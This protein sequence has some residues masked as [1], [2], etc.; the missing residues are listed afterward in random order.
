MTASEWITI[1]AILLGYLLS[2]LYAYFNL[3]E[4]VALLELFTKTIEDKLDKVLN[5]T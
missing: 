3:R 4:R 5:G 1:V 2:G